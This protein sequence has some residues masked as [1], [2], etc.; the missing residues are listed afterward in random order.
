[1]ADTALSALSR[2]A[3]RG[4]RR[5]RVVGAAVVALMAALLMLPP[6]GHRLVVTGDEARFVLLAR[7]MLQRGTWFDARVREQRYRNKPPLYPWSIKVL[8]MPSG[9]VTEGTASLPIALAAVGAVFFTA[10]L[11]QRL[12]GHRAGLWAGLILATSYGFYEHSQMLLPDVIVVLFSVAALHAFWKSV[13]DP[14]AGR[15]LLVFY[16]MVALG[17]FAKGPMGLLPVLVAAVFAVTGGEGVRGLRRLWTA[18]G[19]VVLLVVSAAWFVPFLTLGGGH[20]F[21]R[22]VVWDDWLSWY[23]GGASPYKYLNVLLE[24]AR[25]FMPWTIVLALPLLLGRRHW[26]EPAYRFALVAAAVPLLVVLLSRNHRTRYLLPVY[27][28]AALL[29]AWWADAHGGERSRAARAAAWLSLAGAAVALVVLALPWLQ[30][31]MERTFADGL[32]WKAALAV[33]G[34]ATMAAVAF[35]AL[36]AGRPVLF[37]H[38]V[39]ALMALMLAVGIWF[40]NDWVNRSQD[41][42]QLAALIER[43]AQGGPVRVFGARFFAI[44]V[45]LGRSMSVLR[46]VRDFDDYIARSDRPVVVLNQRAWAELQGHRTSGIDVL[47]TLRVRKQPM[48]VVRAAAAP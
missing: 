33:V 14:P 23:F 24:L 42:R 4:E 34:A 30:N 36:R 5:T 46:D 48:Y 3:V 32:W 29:V 17:V 8:S 35:V 37:V 45:Y 10:L 20:T 44:D 28:A 1:V 38:G 7:D 11:G 40:Y 6:V 2:E 31:P 25:G 19:L 12:F 13:V 21:A 43:H 41:F 18:A 26:R 39:A 9:Q 47:E 27:P 16:V 15:H 22:R